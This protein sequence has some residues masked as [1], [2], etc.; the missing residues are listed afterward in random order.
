MSASRKGRAPTAKLLAVLGELREGMGRGRFV[1][2]TFQRL[3]DGAGC[4]FNTARRACQRLEQLGLLRKVRGGGGFVGPQGI[5]QANGWIVS[6]LAD[7]Y[8]A[9]F[10]PAQD[11][12]E[13]VGIKVTKSKDLVTSE[14][15]NT[16]DEPLAHSAKG[17][18]ETPTPTATATA[19]AKANPEQ[20]LQED[21]EAHLGTSEPA[22]GEAR[23]APDPAPDPAARPAWHSDI[24]ID[25]DKDPDWAAFREAARP[26]LRG[27]PERDLFRIY[28]TTRRRGAQ[29]ERLVASWNAY[30]ASCGSS[31]PQRP[32]NFLRQRRYELDFLPPDPSAPK[33]RPKG[34]TSFPEMV[35]RRARAAGC[36]PGRYKETWR[37][38]YDRTVRAEADAEEAR[39]QGAEDTQ[40]EPE[41]IAAT[42]RPEPEPRTEPRCGESEADYQARVKA[43]STKAQFHEE[44]KATK[45]RYGAPKPSPAPEDEPAVDPI[46]VELLA[47][48]EDRATV[49]HA[50]HRR[51]PDPPPPPPPAPPEVP[52]LEDFVARGV[53]LGMDAAEAEK[54]WRLRY[55]KAPALPVDGN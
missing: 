4:S 40:A 8:P 49:L 46:A 53:R 39:E 33:P 16:L 48:M 36:W 34:E 9:H 26:H 45:A 12:R 43:E 18:P 30:V 28:C 42:S 7:S 41:P 14:N 19:K 54:H 37:Q 51:A 6:H 44:A 47:S 35:E 50:S 25:R 52:S 11:R 38:L 22:E 5:G 31:W 23:R 20:R 29:G 24:V 27:L 17:N 15:R 55:G 13:K 3:A 2:R 10:G 21:R 1:A 32:D